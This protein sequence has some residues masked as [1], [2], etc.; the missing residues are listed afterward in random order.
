MFDIRRR[1]TRLRRELTM[2]G[3]ASDVMNR[4]GVDSTRLRGY[5][6]ACVLSP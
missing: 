1:R 5:S 2:S 3:L 6:H 4:T